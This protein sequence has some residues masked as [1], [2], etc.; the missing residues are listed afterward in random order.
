LVDNVVQSYQHLI[1]LVLLF[2]STKYGFRY[3]YFFIYL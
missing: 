3:C 2:V 1:M